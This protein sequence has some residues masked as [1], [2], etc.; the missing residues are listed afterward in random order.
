MRKLIPVAAALFLSLPASALAAGTPDEYH[1]PEAGAWLNP[2]ARMQEIRRIEIESHCRGDQVVM[3]MRAFTRCSPRDCRWGWVDAR[4][5]GQGRIVAVFP[6][7]FGAR[8]IQVIPMEQRIEAL[9]TFRP[10]DRAKAAEF[11]AAFMVRD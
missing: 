2:K 7:L 9:V 3:R 4:R 8:E 5:T 10:H 1:V 11:H 6:G